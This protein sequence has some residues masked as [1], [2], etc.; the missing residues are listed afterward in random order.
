MRYINLRYLLTYWVLILVLVLVLLVLDT[1]WLKLGFNLEF[2]HVI[3]PWA[4]PCQNNQANNG[5]NN[6]RLM[7]QN[8]LSGMDRAGIIWFVSYLCSKA[9]CKC[10]FSSHSVWSAHRL[11]EWLITAKWISYA[12]YYCMYTGVYAALLHGYSHP[13][14]AN[15]LFAANTSV[16]HVRLDSPW[17]AAPVTGRPACRVEFAVSSDVQPSSASPRPLELRLRS[18]TSETETTVWSSPTD[19]N[20]TVPR[21][22][23]SLCVRCL[24]N[25]QMEIKVIMSCSHNVVEKP[26]GKVDIQQVQSTV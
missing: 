26:S 2:V 11:L 22:V 16:S 21:S 25:S 4:K 8:S 1:S 13:S 6:E 12:M 3:Y 19:W 23:H 10:F 20:H 9:D 24:Y 17:Y 14:P 5:L 15:S 18:D 7:V